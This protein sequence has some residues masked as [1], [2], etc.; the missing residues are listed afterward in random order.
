[1]RWGYVPSVGSRPALRMKS[2]ETVTIDSVSH[3]GILEDQGRDT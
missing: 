1:M 2:G 3:E